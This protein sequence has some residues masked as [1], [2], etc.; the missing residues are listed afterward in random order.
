MTLETAAGALPCPPLVPVLFPGEAAP[1]CRLRAGPCRAFNAIVDRARFRAEVAVLRL[2]AGHGLALGAGTT[3]L[4][5]VE[6]RIALDGAVLEAGDTLV[7][8]SDRVQ[9][10]EAPATAVR[11][12]ITQVGA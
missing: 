9:A 3:A 11:V 1:S 6:G 2:A 8:G 10:E 12:V 7:G 5:C 4:H